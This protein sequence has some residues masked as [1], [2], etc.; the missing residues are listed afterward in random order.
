M[1]ASGCSE[2]EGRGGGRILSRPCIRACLGSGGDHAYAYVWVL[3]EKGKAQALPTLVNDGSVVSR[4]SVLARQDPR[5]DDGRR[6]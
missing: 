4:A 1:H 6:V 3:V 2:M 5:P